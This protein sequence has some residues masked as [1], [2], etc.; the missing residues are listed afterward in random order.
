MER[1]RAELVLLCDLNEPI[2]HDPSHGGGDLGLDRLDEVES[3]LLLL[4]TWKIFQWKGQA[5]V[6]FR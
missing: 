3:G 2:D 5:P 1:L 6:W 4:S